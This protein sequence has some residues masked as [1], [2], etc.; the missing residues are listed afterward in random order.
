MDEIWTM[1]RW[2]NFA[3]LFVGGITIVYKGAL[4]L[5]LSPETFSWSRMMNGL[6]VFAAIEATSEQLYLSTSPGP[7]VLILTAVASIQIWVALAKFNVK[8]EAG[9]EK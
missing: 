9:Y 3:L 5:A 2:L 6:W 1:V 8:E 4:K 7:R